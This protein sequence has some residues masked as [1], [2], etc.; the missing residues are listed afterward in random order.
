MD[1]LRNIARI[2]DV[3]VGGKRVSCLKYCDSSLTELEL[4]LGL[5]VLCSRAW[6]FK[7]QELCERI[8]EFLM[9]PKASG[10]PVPEVCSL[11]L[12]FL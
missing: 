11:S 4:S 1:D 12:C 3:E 5:C 2:L 6:A 10:K 8:I 9:K 7:Q